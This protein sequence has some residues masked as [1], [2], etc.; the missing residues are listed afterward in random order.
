VAVRVSYEVRIR[1]QVAPYKWTKKSK[2][3]FA[4]SSSE[5]AAKYKGPGLIMWVQKVSKEKLL[6]IGEFFTMGDTLLREFR[7]G[8]G[9]LLEQVRRDENKQQK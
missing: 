9:G 7:Q 2:F 3:Y 8:G 6:G 1:E 4:K 5:A